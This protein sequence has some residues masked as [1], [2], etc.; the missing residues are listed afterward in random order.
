MK[1]KGT[2]ISVGRCW[3]RS[4]EAVTGEL[5][6]P[7]GAPCCLPDLGMCV[8]PIFPTLEAVYG[9]NLQGVKCEWDCLDWICHRTQARL[10][11]EL[12]R[13]SQGCGSQFVLRVPSTPPTKTSLVCKFLLSLLK[14][15][16]T[17]LEW[18]SSF[19]SLSLHSWAGARLQTE[20]HFGHQKLS[21][22]TPCLAR[23]R[24]SWTERGTEWLCFKSL[25]IWP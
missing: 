7:M 17:N 9:H 15:P 20:K 18:F 5:D 6:G 12:L 10:L 25:H 13:L 3:K 22:Q 14:P 21:P 8:H 2:W 1:E 19:L 23:T 24:S 4:K 16:L 11:C